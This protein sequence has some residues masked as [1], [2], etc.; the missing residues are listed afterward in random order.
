MK[1]PTLFFIAVDA[2]GGFHFLASLLDS[3]KRV[4]YVR[5]YLNWRLED[6]D[7]STILSRFQKIRETACKV[8]PGEYWG[9]KVDTRQ[10]RFVM[11]YLEIMDIQPST[12]PWIWQCRRDKVAQARSLIRASESDIWSIRADDVDLEEKRNVQVEIDP[13]RL[14]HWTR[15]FT[16][17]EIGWPKFFE[18]Y[19]ITPYTIFYE[20][21]IDP[22]TWESTVSGIYNFLGVSYQSPLNPKT[23]R[24]K[25]AI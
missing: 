20:D 5:E 19:N 18:T 8:G 3:T 24:V 14:D 2:R 10:L 25:Q 11:R 12:V 13:R 7:D 22:S 23:R 4:G 15:H 17:M 16:N 6:L 1:E 9:M 21:F